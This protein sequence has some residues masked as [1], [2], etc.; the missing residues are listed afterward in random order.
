V[1][2][3]QNGLRKAAHSSKFPVGTLKY[4]WYEHPGMG[5]FEMK[6]VEINKP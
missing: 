1:E 3:H 4:H 5:K 2:E 6:E